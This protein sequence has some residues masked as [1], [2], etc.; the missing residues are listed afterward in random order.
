MGHWLKL[1]RWKAEWSLGNKQ[2]SDALR[3]ARASGYKLM[4]ERRS[5]DLR[6]RE[7]RLTSLKKEIEARL[8]RER[9]LI[10]SQANE[11]RSGFDPLVGSQKD[12]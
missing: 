4:E 7:A 12:S 1:K 11:A 6:D 8:L 5:E 3:T 10:E 2:Y 9:S